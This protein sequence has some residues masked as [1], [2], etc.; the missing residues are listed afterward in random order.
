[1]GYRNKAW[2]DPDYLWDGECVINMDR[3]SAGGNLSA[4]T[5]GKMLVMAS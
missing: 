5:T 2:I 3:T 1:M 4:L